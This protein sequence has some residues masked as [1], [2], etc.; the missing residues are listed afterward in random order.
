MD[1]AFGNN[2]TL[3]RVVHTGDNRNYFTQIADCYL[4]GQWIRRFNWSYN[5]DVR[6]FQKGD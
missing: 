1:A 3:V 4:F 2:K 5:I 6:R